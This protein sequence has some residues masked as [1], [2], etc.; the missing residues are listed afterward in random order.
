MQRPLIGA[1]VLAVSLTVG[2]SLL[3]KGSDA[4]A[5][6]AG[7]RWGAD[8]FPNSQVITHN[9]EKLNFYD[10]LIKD[11][12]VVVNFIYTSCPDICSL[13]T[14]RMALVQEKLGDRLGRTI[15]IY[16]ISI[17][18]KTDTPEVLKE[19]AEAFGARPGWLFLTGK[20]S[21]IKVIRFKLGE[22][23]RK[24]S[25][26]RSDVVLGNDTTGEWSRSSVMANI[27]YLTNDILSLDPKWRN[28]PQDVAG[29][30]NQVDPRLI[31]K[32]KRLTRL[33]LTNRPGE[34]LFLKAC[35]SCHSIGKGDRVGPDLMGVV[36]RR[37]HDWLVN[38]MMHPAAMRAKKDPIALELDKKYKGVRMP[39]L[40]L[41]KTDSED[42][43][44]YFE[45]Q[46]KRVRSRIAT[47]KQKN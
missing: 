47:D 46:T 31:P 2:A 30:K 17:D 28:N 21:D 32:G 35:S 37:D 27:D 44:K 42:L 22:R 10:D 24:L 33:R 7:A 26:H 19:Y 12:M 38:F 39:Y 5:A 8:Y 14:A 16:S 34:A 25:E 20:P 41:A 11:K 23:S 15:F 6:P 13:S 18:P 43:I 29:K 9:G 3:L 4:D 45:S 40:G 36:A 1:V